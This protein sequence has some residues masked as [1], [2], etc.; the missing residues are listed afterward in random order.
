LISEIYQTCQQAGAV[1]KQLMDEGIKTILYF[2]ETLSGIKDSWF[3]RPAKGETNP[4]DQENI[5]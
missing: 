5:L 4:A 3:L 2:E 1:H